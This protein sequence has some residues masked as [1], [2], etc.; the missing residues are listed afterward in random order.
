MMYAFRMDSVRVD[1]GNGFSEV[2]VFVAFCTEELKG[3]VSALVPSE[4]AMI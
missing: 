1:S 3:G 4:I 2:D